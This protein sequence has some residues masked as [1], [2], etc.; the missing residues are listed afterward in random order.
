MEISILHL[1]PVNLFVEITGFLDFK[2]ILALYGVCNFI[3]E[4]IEELDILGKR[5]K[6]SKFPLVK[7]LYFYMMRKH[8]YSTSECIIFPLLLDCALK[9]TVMTLKNR[10]Q[11]GCED[12]AL[13]IIDTV[14]FSEFIT[15]VT[16]WSHIGYYAKLLLDLEL[17]ALR[18]CTL[19]KEALWIKPT[20]HFNHFFDPP[21]VTSSL[22]PIPNSI[23]NRNAIRFILDTFK[24]KRSFNQTLVRL[25]RLFFVSNKLRR[26]Y[27]RIK[28]VDTKTR[29]A[30][31]MLGLRQDNLLF[32]N[33][34]ILSCNTLDYYE[35]FSPEWEPIGQRDDAID[36]HG[37]DSDGEISPDDE[38]EF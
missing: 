25:N 35:V 16:L 3:R 32:P 24:Q 22:H 8:D 21:R 12:L 2:E 23:S 28:F 33:G 10:L 37:S 19:T 29:L 9:R 30:L 4:L 38:P 15:P 14:R 20:L 1:L 36:I 18:Y 17:V 11:K 27:R 5:I 7:N 13:S 34:S 31:F 6:S 26:Y